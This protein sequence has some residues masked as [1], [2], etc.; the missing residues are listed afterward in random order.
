MSIVTFARVALNAPADAE[1]GW[2]GS[3]ARS[4]NIM[5]CNSRRAELAMLLAFNFCRLARRC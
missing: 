1:S 3:A 4:V 5:S 2:Q